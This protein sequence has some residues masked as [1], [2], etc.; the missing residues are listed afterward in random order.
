MVVYDTP[1]SQHTFEVSN[2]VQEIYVRIIGGTGGSTYEASGGPAGLV[3]GV[4]PVSGGET[5]NVYV[6]ET[7]GDHVDWLDPTPGTGGSSPLGDGGDGGAGG[8]YEGSTA[9]GG[10]GGGAASGIERLSDN[11]QTRS[12]G[13]GGAGGDYRPTGDTVGGGGGGGGSLGGSGGVGGTGPDSGEDGQDAEGSG[14]GG[15]GGDGG[16]DPDGP[17]DGSSGGVVTQSDLDVSNTGTSTSGPLVEI[18]E[19]PANPTVSAS[20]VGDDQID[21]SIDGDGNQDYFNV[22]VQRDDGSWVNPAGG[23]S[24]PSTSGTYSYGPHNSGGDPKTYFASVGIDSRFDFR[25][26]AVNDAGASD[27]IYSDPIYTTPIPPKNV[28]VSRPDADTIEVHYEASSDVANARFIELREDS[29]SGYGSWTWINGGSV[30][31]T[32]AVLDVGDELSGD[33]RY[34]VRMR[35]RN[36]RVSGDAEFSE[37]VYTDYGNEGNV[38]FEDDFSSGDTSAW[39]TT[40][41]SATVTGTLDSVFTAGDNT[42]NPETGGY[43]VEMG[44]SGYL[45]KNLGDLSGESDVHVRL[46]VQLASND[47]ADERGDVWWYDGSSWQGLEQWTWAH[48]GQGWMSY[49]ATV[50]SSY[51]SS[52]NRVRIGRNEGGGVDYVAFDEVIVS[53]ILHEYTTPAA[54]SA[55]TIDTSVEDEISA[56]WTLNASHSDKSI[57]FQ[58]WRQRRTDSGDDL[59]KTNVEEST[60]N[61]ATGLLDG[62]QY[63]IRVDSLYEQKRHGSTETWWR[64]SSSLK[65]PIARLPAPTTFTVDTITATTADVSWTDN[66]DYGDTQVQFKPTDEASWTTYSTVSRGTEV[67]TITGLRNGEKYDARALA[68]TEHTTTEDN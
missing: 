38:Y 11:A 13:G 35:H 57:H 3:E 24:E 43:A 10:A 23:P 67:E 29:G 63:D 14:V 65:Q 25:V 33:A 36:N 30:D 9:S 66:H 19:A 22:E 20:Y 16:E 1:N 39:D 45:Q 56:S 15:N 2:G 48:D 62:E 47:A 37:W 8:D 6:G 27:W 31:G 41:G 61:T 4:L 42:Q 54:P 59:S 58:E 7:G 17:E 26:R 34:Q 60:E 5:F 53:D 68:A 51:L 28:S 55:L 49:H 32:K 18:V 50:P 64:A 46:T 40:S 12:G 52:D 44:G 21:L